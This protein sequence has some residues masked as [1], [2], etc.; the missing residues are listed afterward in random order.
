MFCLHLDDLQIVREQFGLGV[1]GG[2]HQIHL[3]T[4]TQEHTVEC[5]ELTLKLCG[6][7]TLLNKSLGNPYLKILD[8]SQLFIAITTKN[9]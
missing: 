8:F 2:R 3:R 9:S 6:F 7:L 5:I 4:R 1:R